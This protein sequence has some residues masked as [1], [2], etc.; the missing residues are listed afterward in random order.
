[1]PL[2]YMYQAESALLSTGDVNL[3]FAT[4]NPLLLI[5]LVT[6]FTVLM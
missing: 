4:S 6:S 3:R 2:D 1:M 5:Y